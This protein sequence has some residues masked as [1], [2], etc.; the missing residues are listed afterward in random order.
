M[1]F[2]PATRK[3]TFVLVG[4]TGKSG[5][6]KTYSALKL[7]R[8]LVGPAGRIAFI[9]TE[10]GR[11]SHYS[12]VTA[13]DID[14]LWP[15]F[16]PGRYA[17]KI[18]A[19]ADAGYHALI[20]D[21]MSH[22]WEGQGGVL[23]K[24]DATGKQGL[25]KWM[26]PKT[27]H[28]KLVNLILQTRMHIIV[29]LR[30]KEKLVQAKDDRGKEVIVSQ[31]IVPIQEDRLLYEMT[32]SLITDEALKPGVPLVRKCPADLM[33]AFQPGQQISERTGQMIAEWVGGGAPVDHQAE[34]WKRE[35]REVA[36]NGSAAMRGHWTAADPAKR[37]ALQAILDELKSIAAEA[38]R[39]AT[40]YS[41]EP[42]T[43]QAGDPLDDGPV[44]QTAVAPDLAALKKTLESFRDLKSLM[45]W[46]NGEPMG[47]I[48]TILEDCDKA[49]FEDL[50]ALYDH[51]RSALAGQGELLRSA[52]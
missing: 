27:E 20:I 39:Q 4:I 46:W 7:A 2:H 17:E 23:E 38:D 31:G 44:R 51:R 11:G 22:E 43:G 32:V 50:C 19:A 16:S 25:Q 9:D 29:C 24:A 18:K 48:M 34:A 37:Q 40:E 12:D 21:S 13:Y 6:G 33:A 47:E 41:S 28:K 3:G 26:K 8:G 10:T 42:A 15:P 52:P 1:A 36:A 14:E 35:A 5:T 45:A 49:G 30:G